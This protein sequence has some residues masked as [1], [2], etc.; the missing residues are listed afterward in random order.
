MAE[1]PLLECRSMSKAF[2]AVQA[3]Y[4]VDFEVRPGEVMA[5]VGDNG[6][7]KSTLI[8]G[9][10]GI[11]PFDEGEVRFEGAAGPHPRAPRRGQARDR[12]RVPGPRAGRQPRRRRPTCSSAASATTHGFVLDEAAMEQRRARRSTACRSRRLRSVRQ[13]GRRPV[14]RPAP[15]G[16]GGEGGDVELQG[17]HPRRADRGPRRRPDAAGAR[18][19]A[20]PRRPRARRS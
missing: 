6:A 17:G 7:G 4:H 20:P 15:G 2:G 9:I 10:A 14:G 13:L 16:G 8:K 11:Y 5:L 3:L 19:R 1:T 12:G 18:P